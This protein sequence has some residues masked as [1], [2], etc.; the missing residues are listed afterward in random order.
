MTRWH[1]VLGNPDPSDAW[2]AFD[3]LAAIRRA[4]AIDRAIA[5][6]DAFEAA[7]ARLSNPSPE[8][9]AALWA[10]IDKEPTP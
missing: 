1:P 4:E 3:K 9:V 5:R 6:R 8:A 2:Y 10:E 7:L